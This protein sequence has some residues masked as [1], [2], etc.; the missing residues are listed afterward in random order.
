MTTPLIEKLKKKHTRAEETRVE[1]PELSHIAH[2]YIR[3]YIHANKQN[4]SLMYILYTN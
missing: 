3:T 4:S 1:K 2:V